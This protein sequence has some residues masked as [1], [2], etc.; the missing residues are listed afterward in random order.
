MS[1]DPTTT[2]P[3][4]GPDPELE[5]I[6]RELEKHASEAGWDG[7]A[8]LFALVPTADLL[9]REPGL[10]EVLED[11]GGLT[12]V[13]QDELPPQELEAL[14]QSIVWPLQVAGCAAVLERLVLPP[15]ADADIPDDPAEAAAFAAAHPDRQELRIAG[16]V[17]RD[18]RGT[19]AL[20]L[21]SHDDDASVVVGDELVPGLLDLLAGTLDD[22]E[23]L[24]EGET[25]HDEEAP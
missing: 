25:P 19:C 6:V 11:T 21:R 24:G 8:R 20:R 1:D 23:P 12:P 17:T 18:G 3:P 14:L 16:A 10:A 13:Q 5:R 15:G 7:P 9:A 4:A 22:S 2:T